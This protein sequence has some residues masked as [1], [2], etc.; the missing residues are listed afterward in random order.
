MN[1]FDFFFIVKEE[2]VPSL[3][4]AFPVRVLPS[5]DIVKICFPGFI[6]VKLDGPRV[7]L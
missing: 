5:G 2:D 3:P 1:Q 4:V 7:I 6:V